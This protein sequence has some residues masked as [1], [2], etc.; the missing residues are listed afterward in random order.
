[1]V[2]KMVDLLVT[3]RRRTMSEYEKLDSILRRGSG[4]KLQ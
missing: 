2:D 1:M 3:Q 4:E